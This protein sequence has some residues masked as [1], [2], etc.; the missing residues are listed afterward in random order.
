[1]TS[2]L[3][4]IIRLPV[5]ALLIT[6]LAVLGIITAVVY[7][8]LTNRRYS[9]RIKLAQERS[10]DLENALEEVQRK[11][12]ANQ[13][14]Q[15]Q[16]IKD[17]EDLRKKSEITRAAYI[18]FL[19]NISHEVSNPLQSIQTNLDNMSEC[20][21]ENREGINRYYEIIS[22]DIKRLAEFTERLRTLSRLES[23]NRKIIREPVNLRG[24][25]ETVLMQQYDYAI[26]RRVNL[27]YQGP[28]QLKRIVAN[29]VDMEQVFTNLIDN[30]IKYSKD[31]GGVV[32]I[33]IEENNDSFLIRVI[34]DGIGI[35]A[36]DLPHIFDVAYRS[37]ETFVSRRKGTGLGLSIVKQ[38]IEQYGGSISAKSDVDKGT[39]ITFEL[40]IDQTADYSTKKEKN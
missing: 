27:Q 31:N 1:M 19:Y 34:D 39:T 36:E 15:I 22:S 7:M 18:N 11:L 12:A 40:P 10:Q 32:I 25:I 2:W 21:P 17:Y 16:F 33:H 38:I 30:S 4:I 24:V 14:A 8:V 3:E 23:P 13:E 6:L 37:P 29:R 28:D 9:K 5:Y 20:P 35:P 26:E